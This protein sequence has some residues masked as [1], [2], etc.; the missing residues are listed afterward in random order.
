MSATRLKQP[1]TDLNPFDIPVLDYAAV[2]AAREE[3]A[4]IGARL[5]KTAARRIE[6]WNLLCTGARA[7]DEESG[8]LAR[9]RRLLAGDT[10][11]AR[12]GAG[13][14]TPEELAL[15]HRQLGNEE[16]LLKSALLKLSTKIDREISRATQHRKAQPDFAQA[17]EAL[18]NAVLNLI[19]IHRAGFELSERIAAKGFDLSEAT[20]GWSGAHL[21][22]ELAE[23]LERVVSGERVIPMDMQR[24]TA[25]LINRTL[26]AMRSPDKPSLR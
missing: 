18:A 4:A 19:E 15:E 8:I 2:R 25:H 11:A 7:P 5:A 17:R 1:E 24:F 3:H 16:E 23:S 12:S 10:T 14:P 26:T 13:S 21:P 20:D 9:T 22:M 6:T